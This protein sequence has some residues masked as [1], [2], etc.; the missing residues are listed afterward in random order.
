[1]RKLEFGSY[2]TFPA[3]TPIWSIDL[4]ETV[5]IDKEL[6]VQIGASCLPKCEDYFVTKMILLFNLPGCIPGLVE[7]KN[8]FGPVNEKY[9][10]PYTVPGPLFFD[11]KYGNDEL[12]S[13]K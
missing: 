10:T 9:L 5:Q 8:E 12:E 3:N 2:A 13:T 6:I 4:Q 7:T 1:M 11:F